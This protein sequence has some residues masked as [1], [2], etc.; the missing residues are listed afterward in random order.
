M[1]AGSTPAD[2]TMKKREINIYDK[3]I[4]LLLYYRNL[5]RAIGIIDALVKEAVDKSANPGSINWK[6]L[7]TDIYDVYTSI[8]DIKNE[9]EKGGYYKKEE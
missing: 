9:I 4:D 3:D 6:H 1:D 2:P 5:S 7:K 8:K